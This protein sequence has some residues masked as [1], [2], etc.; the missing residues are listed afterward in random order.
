MKKALKV[1]GI[2]VLSVLLIATAAFSV[3]WYRFTDI[4]LIIYNKYL[5]NSSEFQGAKLYTFSEK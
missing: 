3:Y 4:L 1:A 2:I 5:H